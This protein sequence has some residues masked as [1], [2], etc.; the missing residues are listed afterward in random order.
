MKKLFILAFVAFA[1]TFAANAQ[2]PGSAAYNQLLDKIYAVQMQS[3]TMYETT[4]AGMNTLVEQGLMT[5]DNCDAF[6]REMVDAM[7][8]IIEPKFK[9]LY[10]DN[11]TYK[12]LQ[13]ILDW[14]TSP[15]GKKFMTIMPQSA[16]IG[17]EA[18]TDP[19]FQAKMMEI[20]PKYMSVK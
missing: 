7:L 3:N 4:R 19:A 1:A 18:A 17:Q 5:S 12:E 9:K 14:Q 6:C 11:F 8:P 2:A 13:Q 20:M 10:S 15:I 16:A